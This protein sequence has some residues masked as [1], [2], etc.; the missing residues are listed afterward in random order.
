MRDCPFAI[1]VIVA[2]LFFF[3]FQIFDEDFVWI[4]LILSFFTVLTYSRVAVKSTGQ[5][6]L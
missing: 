3:F 4:N 1:K 6:R 5:I 2:Y